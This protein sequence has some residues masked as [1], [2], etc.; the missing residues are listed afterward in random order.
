MRRKAAASGKDRGSTEARHGLARVL[1][2]LGYC[3]RSAAEELVRAGRVSVAGRRVLDPQCPT[4]AGLDAISVDDSPVVASERVYL[5]LNKPRGLVTTA[6]DER[7]RGTV[8]ECLRGTSLPWLGPVGR[9]DRASEGL[10]LFTNDTVWAARV[11]AP[12]AHLEKTYHVQVDRIPDAGELEA[13]RA[14]VMVEGESLGAL[15]VAVLREGTRNAWLEVVL[16]E[17]RNRQIRRL[18][19]ALEIGVLRLVRVAIGNL[20]LGDLEKGKWR[21]LAPEEV[22]AIATPTRVSGGND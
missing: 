3:S 18:L 12:A 14:G 10:L 16:D 5:M 2:K 1:A 20:V 22:A 9:L 4:R 15:R 17:G 7:G 19:S 6:T 11:T 21:A 8:Y 13:M